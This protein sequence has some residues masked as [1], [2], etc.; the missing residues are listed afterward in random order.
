LAGSGKRGEYDDLLGAGEALE[1]G[2]ADSRV[3]HRLGI[4]EVTAAGLTASLLD[5]KVAW[6]RAPEAGVV[7][8]IASGG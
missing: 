8:D 4:A 7:I 3:S 2:C 6:S 1:E 5:G